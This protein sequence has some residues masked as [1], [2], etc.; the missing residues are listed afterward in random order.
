[1]AHYKI[2]S[3]TPSDSSHRLLIGLPLVVISVFCFGLVLMHPNN[4]N[5]VHA[6]ANAHSSPSTNAS[7]KLSPISDNPI[8]AK[9]TP[10]T[11]TTPAPTTNNLSTTSPT[12]STPV[13][14]SPQLSSTGTASLQAASSNTSK[15]STGS[16]K[17]TTIRSAVRALVTQVLH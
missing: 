7:T 3:T 17:T 11:T 15:T 16:G 14:T 9:L 13:T 6:T 5:T 2:D 1:M 8:P 12:S 10:A 4:D